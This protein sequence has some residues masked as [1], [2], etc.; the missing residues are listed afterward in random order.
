MCGFARFQVV[1]GP[2][3][4]LHSCMCEFNEVASLSRVLCDSTVR[5]DTEALSGN[6]LQPPAVFGQFVPGLRLLASDYTE[7]SDDSKFPHV[8]PR[9]STAIPVRQLSGRAVDADRAVGL[10]LGNFDV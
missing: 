4:S 9:C 3:L 7:S 6:R 10:E 2:V 8:I 1:T 5:G